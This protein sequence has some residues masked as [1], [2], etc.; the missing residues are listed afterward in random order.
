MKLDR[1]MPVALLLIVAAFGPLPAKAQDVV[2][3]SGTVTVTTTPPPGPQDALNRGTPRGSIVGYLEACSTFDFEKAAEFLDL[4]NLPEEARELG[5]KELA[6]Q[7]NHVLSRSVWLDDYNVSDD[8]EGNKGDGLPEY[9]DELVVIRRLHGEQEPLWLQHIP[10]GDGEKIWKVSNRSVALIPE[11]YEEFSYPQ[12]IEKIRALFPEEA[13][14]LGLEAFKWFILITVILLSWPVFY[15]LGRLLT[16]LFSNREKEIYPVIRQ[17]LTGPFVALGILLI[18]G[19]F[20]EELGAGAYAQ[21]IMKANTLSILVV[22]WALWSIINLYKKHKQDKLDKLG[23]PGAAKLM[24]PMAGFL[25][26]VILVFGLLFWLNNIG[27]NITTLL[28]GLGVGGLAIALALQKPIEDMMGAFTIFS[29]A[30]LRVGDFCRYGEI[31]GTVEDIG[32][33]TT[34]LRTLTN[35]LVS[36]P[37]SRIAYM[38]VEN[39]TAREK[40]RFWP[41]L[42][43]RYDTT[44]EQLRSVMDNILQMLEQHQRVHD[45]PL[46]VRLTDFDEDAILVKVHSFLKTIDF[47]EALEIGEDLNFRILEIIHSAGARFAL[48][49]KSIYM[50]GEEVSPHFSTEQKPA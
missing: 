4:R 10:R 45:E 44:P 37:N 8:P 49:G 17:A 40:I 47:P 38:E 1:K 20:L 5:G 33:R 9:R 21:Q 12:I 28:A 3:E 27:V 13:A 50:E 22:V 15:L 24:R 46:R 7:L 35:T 48:P 25:K 32:L 23:R 43:L 2:T 19:L 26:I 16:E 34:R 29:Q 6:R 11:L 42:R 18:G 41:T 31:T 30:T 14:L 39:F 36:I